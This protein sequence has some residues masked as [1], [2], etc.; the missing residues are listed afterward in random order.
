MHNREHIVILRPGEQGILLHTMYYA[1][2]I[3]K[4]DEFRTDTRQIKENE[5]KLATTL[6]ESLAASFEPEKYTDT[7]RAALMS[8][9]EARKAGRHLVEPPAPPHLAPVV[10]IL[11]ALKKSLENVKKPVKSVALAAAAEPA[12]APKARRSRK[13]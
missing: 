5:L 8:L 13:S 4:V 7:Y 6:V 12:A 1:D 11:D 2:E 10:D 9:I 3:R